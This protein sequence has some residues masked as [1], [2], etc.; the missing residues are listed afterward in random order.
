VI[1]DNAIAARTAGRKRCA[2]NAAK[3]TIAL[4]NPPKGARIIATA[5]AITASAGAPA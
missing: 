2:C 1:G 3:P 5:S 4:N